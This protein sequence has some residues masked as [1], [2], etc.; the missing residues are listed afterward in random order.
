M[1][2]DVWN[3]FKEGNWTDEINVRDFIQKN[4]TAY[5]GDSSFLCGPTERTKALWNEVLELY[6]KER[7]K[8]GVLDVSLIP[9]DINAHEAGYINKD[10]ELIVGLQTDAPLKRAIMPK[11]GI[12][13]VEKSLEAQNI[14]LPEDLNKIFNDYAKTH[15]Q[16][17]F[18]AYT[19]EIRRARSSH[20]IT[21]LPDRI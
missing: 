14:S 16:G 19:P 21:G 4:Y 1:R 20:L 5:E 15:N 17:V 9:S 11:G 3:G 7:E 18:D 8:G 6:K 10:K 2:F 13:I 12:R